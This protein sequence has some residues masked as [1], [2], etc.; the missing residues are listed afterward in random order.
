MNRL[1]YK[2]FI[3]NFSAHFL[4]ICEFVKNIWFR[5]V[6][7][8]GGFAQ[9]SVQFCSKQPKIKVVFSLNLD[10]LHILSKFEKVC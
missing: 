3:Y 9:L 10:K 7:L 2:Q 5:L 8:H 6:K 1:L 4:L